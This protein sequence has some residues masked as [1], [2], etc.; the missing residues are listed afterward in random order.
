ME[1]KHPSLPALPKMTVNP[2]LPVTLQSWRGNCWSAQRHSI[3]AQLYGGSCMWAF[4]Y[5]AVLSW[6]PSWLKDN[7]I[8]KWQRKKPA[9][10]RHKLSVW[11]KFACC[12]LY[13]MRNKDHLVPFMV[14]I[15]LYCYLNH[16]PSE[17][18]VLLTMLRI[19]YTEQWTKK[20]HRTWLVAC[21]LQTILSLLNCTLRGV[22]T[23][24]Y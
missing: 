19:T 16:V 8:S 1:I 13:R 21:P 22:T 5:L 2:A 11:C 17:P 15:S 4:I 3:M 9:K 20:S 10:S 24:S 6:Y 18:R 7:V 12:W 14:A 23:I